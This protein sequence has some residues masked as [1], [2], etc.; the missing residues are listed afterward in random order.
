VSS[1]VADFVSS[2]DTAAQ[3]KSADTNRPV[4][5]VLS[6]ASMSG[7]SFTQVLGDTYHH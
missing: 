6:S 5:T 4:I 7:Q 3:Q 1:F 2:F